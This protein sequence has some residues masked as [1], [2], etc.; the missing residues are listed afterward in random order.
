MHERPF[1][2]PHV[3]DEAAVVAG[4][5]RHDRRLHPLMEHVRA[6]LHLLHEVPDYPATAFS[7]AALQAMRSQADEVVE[8]IE[9]YIDAGN[10]TGNAA[11]QLAEAVYDIRAALEEID[12]W[13]RH[14]MEADRRFP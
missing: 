13:H 3:I 12:R 9:A 5:I 4:S 8:T 6:F 10:A 2:H 1:V 11:Q 14:F 7:S